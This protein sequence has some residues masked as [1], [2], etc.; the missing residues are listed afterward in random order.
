M[1]KGFSLIELIFVLSIISFIA[2]VALPKFS[3]SI[4]KTNLVK[5]KGDVA[6][7]REALISYKNKLILSN[8]VEQLES[9]DENGRLFGKILKYPIETSDTPKKAAWKKISNSSYLVYIDQ[10]NSVEFVYDKD[11]FTFDCDFDKK[12]CEELMQ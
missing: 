2:V 4:D 8:S 1:K 12:H 9:L 7:I 6:F 3:S 5:I 11:N 10:E